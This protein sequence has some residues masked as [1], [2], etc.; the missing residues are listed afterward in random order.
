[1]A[2]TTAPS[3]ARRLQ[4]PMGMPWTPTN[5]RAAV[6]SVGEL[7]L[8]KLNEELERTEWEVG[9]TPA[10]LAQ[11]AVARPVPRPV[12]SPSPS[13]RHARRMR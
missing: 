5:S 7:D 10:K 11:S 1:M 8:D 3:Q 6:P 2:K 9:Y 4:C 12:P 13:P